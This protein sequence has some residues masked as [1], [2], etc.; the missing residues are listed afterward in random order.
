[1][2]FLLQKITAQVKSQGSF[3]DAG[4]AVEAPLREF[5]ADIA[6]NIQEGIAQDMVPIELEPANKPTEQ[7]GVERPDRVGAKKHEIDQEV[8]FSFP[9]GIFPGCAEK[10][11]IGI[12]GHGAKLGPIELYRALAFARPGTGFG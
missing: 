5:Y 8:F 9:A 7:E 11:D 3:H 12:G 10:G 1:M 6:C 2:V 4:G